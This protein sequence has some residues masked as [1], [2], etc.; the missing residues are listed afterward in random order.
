M[1]KINQITFLG[2][3]LFPF[4][5]LAQKS[6]VNV[7][8]TIKDKVSNEALPFVTVQMQRPDSSLVTGTISNEKGLF[9]IGGIEPGDYLL[10]ISYIGYKKYI[11][12]LYV[13]SNS[14]FIDVGAIVLEED[15][16]QL[17]EVV[18]TAQQDAVSGQ[19]DKKTFTVEDNVSQGGGSVL[20]SMQNLPGVTTQDGQ[21]QLRGNDQVMIL[22]DGK[23]TAITG[24]GNQNGLDNIPAS[25]V[26]KIE[27]INN[28]SAK[29]DA[30]G[31]G[32]IINIVMKKEEQ[33][34]FNGK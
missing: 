20:Q 34:G 10:K 17:N 13:G 33:K 2:L 24:F 3:L 14:E 30:N 22:I 32:G 23:Q 1:T 4:G 31:N 9:S 5:I 15:V 7:S 16:Q 11:S 26:D 28:P 25:A 18:V 6:S 19:M 27:I 8:G 29:Y 12:A 21:V